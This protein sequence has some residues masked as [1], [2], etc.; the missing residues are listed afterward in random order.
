MI[1]HPLNA[2]GIPMLDIIDFDFPL[3]AYSPMTP[4]I[5]SARQSLQTVGSVALYYLSEFA[6]K[7]DDG[8]T[9]VR[10][11]TTFYP[12]IVNFG[13]ACCHFCRQSDREVRLNGAHRV[14]V[15]ANA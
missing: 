1:M 15:P 7:N 10:I 2:I 6:P 12:F 9:S 14:Y 11:V 4:W 8:R 5:R 13:I 3:V